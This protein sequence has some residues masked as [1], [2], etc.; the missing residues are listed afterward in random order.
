MQFESFPILIGPH[1]KIETK[2]SLLPLGGFIWIS[3]LAQQIQA[4][5]ELY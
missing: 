1:S 3:Y 2:R 5:L 4:D